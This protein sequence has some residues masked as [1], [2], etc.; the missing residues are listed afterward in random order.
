VCWPQTATVDCLQI[1][2]TKRPCCIRR[3]RIL[4]EERTLMAFCTCL[5]LQKWPK[6]LFHVAFRIN[7]APSPVSR[8]TR[9]NSSSKYGTNNIKLLEIHL[10][11][12]STSHVIVTQNH[13]E[14]TSPHFKIVSTAVVMTILGIN[15]EQTGMLMMP[16]VETTPDNFYTNVISVAFHELKHCPTYTAICLRWLYKYEVRIQR[17]V[18]CPLHHQGRG[19]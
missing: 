6:Y 2:P 12:F 15:L 17:F 9:L 14:I 10:Q 1:R 18:R 4:L 3:G 16:D 13:A 5:Q 19:C 7:C 11:G 8:V